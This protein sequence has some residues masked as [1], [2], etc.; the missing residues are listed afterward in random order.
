MQVHVGFD[1]SPSFSA[2]AGSFSD[3]VPMFGSFGSSAM[4]CA[5]SNAT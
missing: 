5:A 1:C 3:H 4:E 2:L